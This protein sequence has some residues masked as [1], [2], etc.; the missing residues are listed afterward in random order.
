MGQTQQTSQRWFILPRLRANQ[1]GE[2]RHA[3]WLESI[4]DLVFAVAITGLI[5]ILRDDPTAP[6]L[7]RFV[8]LFL[9][10]WWAWVGQTVYLSRFDTDDTIQHVITFGHMLA[11]AVMSTQL[12]NVFGGSVGGVIRAAD[13][14]IFVL[15]YLF[16]RY[17]VL[18]MYF[19]ARRAVPE[20]RGLSTVYLIGFGA[21]ALL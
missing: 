18:F 8:L 9:P 19:R 7:A 13:A 5:G 3:T 16:M 2:A 6:G 10:I 11:A 12:T 15:A 1:A 20:A 21:G 17:T 4:Y 14:R